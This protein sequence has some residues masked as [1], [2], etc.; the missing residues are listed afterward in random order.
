MGRARSRCQQSIYRDAAFYCPILIISVPSD[1]STYKSILPENN[2][3]REF[4]CILILLNV[5]VSLL[6]A[7]T[8]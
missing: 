5:T 2:L 1:M 7:E 6:E 4:L 3:M 8:Q